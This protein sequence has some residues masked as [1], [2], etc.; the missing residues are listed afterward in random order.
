MITI[1]ITKKKSNNN[2]NRYSM[3]TFDIPKSIAAQKEYLKGLAKR[4]PDDWMAPNFAQGRGFAPPD[5]SCYRCHRNIYSEG[6]ISVER[7]SKELITGCP[8]CHVSY[9]D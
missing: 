5:G 7:A 6:G 2:Q 8:S 1:V 4:H 3:E 9:V